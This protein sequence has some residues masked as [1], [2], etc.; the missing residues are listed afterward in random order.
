M[1]TRLLPS[2]ASALIA[3][4]T[5][6]SA[7]AAETAETVARISFPF[8]S[9]MLRAN[10]PVFGT[11]WAREFDSYRLEFGEGRRP[12]KWVLIKQSKQPQASDPYAQGKVV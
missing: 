8:E 7:F 3:A 11:A 10:V 6:C 9:S 12:K 2:V 1:H 5:A 4:S